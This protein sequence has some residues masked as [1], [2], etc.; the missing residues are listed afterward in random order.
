VHEYRSARVVAGVLF[1]LIGIGFLLESANVWTV[2]LVYLWPVTL[3]V[4]GVSFLLGRARRLQAEETR[5]AQLAVAEERVR[6]AREL[7]D[8]VAHGVSLMTIQIAGARR[9]LRTKPDAAEEALGAAE[10]A[11]RQSL[12]E[13]RSL[14]AV[15]RS[16]DQ[17]IGAVAGGPAT[18]A[19]PA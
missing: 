2:N 15:L 1:A 14:L 3:I 16:A 8:I 18:S 17:T 11:G 6:I 13:L 10:Q 7:H 12:S 5:A 19:T 4:I 9:V